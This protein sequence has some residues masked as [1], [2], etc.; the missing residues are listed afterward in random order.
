[1]CVPMAAWLAHR[2][3][4]VDNTLPLIAPRRLADPSFVFHER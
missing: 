2:L 3:V 1:M 4:A